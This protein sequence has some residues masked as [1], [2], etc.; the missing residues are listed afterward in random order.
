MSTSSDHSPEPD[1][2]QDAAQAAPGD[3]EV[4]PESSNEDA[5]DDA[6]PGR[7]AAKYRRQLRDAEATRDTL[8]AK[9][10]KYQTAEAERAAAGPGRLLDPTDL[11]RVTE[12]ADVLDDDGELDPAK[13]NTA[14]DK[15]L[16]DKPHYGAPQTS[17]D[18]DLGARG[19]PV[20]AGST[21]SDVIGPPRR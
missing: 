18:L 20:K 14:V 12:L 15:L 1:D 10:S 21:W 11:W 16:A 9:V 5:T 13:V 8:A 19:A 17:L 2:A 7:E 3:Q 4:T 6:N